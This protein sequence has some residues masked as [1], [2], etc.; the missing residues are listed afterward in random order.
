M[1]VHSR[2]FTPRGILCSVAI[3]MVYCIS[4][5]A[6]QP[7]LGQSLSLRL[8]AAQQPQDMPDTQQ[9]D[10]QTP[11]PDQKLPKKTVVLNGTI[12]RSGD[13]FVLRD[14]SGT[15]YKLDDQEKAGFFAGKSVKVTGKL[16]ASINLLHV[17][18]IE[19]ATA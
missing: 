13:A 14:P 2:I 12:V 3:A 15:D 16:E 18:T 11:N 7:M 17:E 8:Q 4:V 10:S 1:K 6:M 5:L 19:E 9:P